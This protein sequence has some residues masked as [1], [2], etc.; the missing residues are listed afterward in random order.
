MPIA[1]MLLTAYQVVPLR[2]LG[3]VSGASG[4]ALTL[5]S[6]GLQAGDLLIGTAA[7]H[8]ND[9]GDALLP[10]GWTGVR[11]PALYDDAIRFGLSY[12]VVGASP[13]ASVTLKSDAADG[14]MMAM[15]FRGTA[16]VAPVMASGF[17]EATMNAPALTATDRALSLVVCA[18]TGGTMSSA[19]TTPPTGWTWIGGVLNTTGINVALGACYQFD[20]VDTIDPGA[21]T[22]N[23]TI[24]EVATHT[25]FSKM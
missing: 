3:S 17:T 18:C 11:G 8:N 7:V 12:L 25:L 16:L 2:F 20:V 4:T 21:M 10:S 9:G 5:T 22:G 1:R 15:A 13:P 6:L 14:V 23:S 24:S 19:P